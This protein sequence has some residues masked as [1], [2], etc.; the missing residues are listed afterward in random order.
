MMSQNINI[1]T[2]PFKLVPLGVRKKF[3]GL[4]GRLLCKTFIERLKEGAAKCETVTDYVDFVFSFEFRILNILRFPIIKPAQIKWEI[5]SLLK[6]LADLKPK[7][8]IEI[9]TA[10][11]GTLFLWTRVADP[12]ATIISI[13]LPGGPFGGGYLAWRIPLYESFALGNQKIYLLRADSHRESTFNKVREILGSSKVDFLFIDGDHSYEG[14][15]KDFEMYSGLV[16]GG[17]SCSSARHR[18][19]PLPS[20]VSGREILA[21]NKE[22]PEI[23]NKGNHLSSPSNMGRDWFG[24]RVGGVVAFHD[25]VPGPSECVGGVPRFWREIKRKFRHT[26]I[27][28]SWGQGGYGIG[29]IFV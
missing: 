24:I 16:G 18:S 11:G 19:S 21:G 15:K 20:R 23:L 27:V 26:E 4:M 3:Y 10:S 29:V 5:L 8:V 28:E 22:E 6:V 7:A 9:G 13:D 25:I 14:V 2:T 12:E 17:G 1:S